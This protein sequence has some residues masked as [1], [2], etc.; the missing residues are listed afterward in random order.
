MFYRH[1]TARPDVR[2][3]PPF[4]LP[5]YVRSVGHYRLEANYTEDYG[6]GDRF[7]QIFWGVSGNGAIRLNSKEYALNP[8][9]VVCKSVRQTHGYRSKSDGWELR[10]FTFDGPL[11]EAFLRRYEYPV[12]LE[13]AGACPLEHFVEIEHGLQAMTPYELRRLA[14]VACTILALAGRKQDGQDAANRVC[15]RFLALVQEHYADP[16]LN[17]NA[18]AAMMQLHRTTLTRLFF[19]TM[20]TSPGEYLQRFR[21]QRALTLLEA[22]TLPVSEVGALVGLPDASQFSRLVRRLTGRTPRQIRFSQPAVFV[23]SAY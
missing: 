21:L 16:Q 23:H 14:G 12:R 9:D 18:L 20:K 15:E 7:A 10:W 8:G 11:A 22:G 5:F 6:K 4:P 17:I 19:Q 2:N 1:I 3:L 13:Q